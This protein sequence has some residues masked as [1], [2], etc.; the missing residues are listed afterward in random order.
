MRRRIDELRD[1]RKRPGVLGNR[2]EVLGRISLQEPAS[3]R[4][5]PQHHAESV[6]V[7]AS[8]AGVAV[9]DFR[10]HVA[11]LGEH[12][13]R[14][15]VA[16]AVLPAR[17]AEVDQLHIAA[18]AEHH[19]LGTQI[20]VHDPQWLAADVHALVHVHERFGCGGRHGHCI[21]PRQAIGKRKGARAHFAQ[22][23][24]FHELDHH[25]RLAL[26]VGRCLED[27]RHTRV[28]ELRLHARFVEE[29]RKEGSILGMF[30]ADDLDDAGA[31]GAFDA[32]GSSEVDLTHASAS[33]ELEQPVTL[34]SSSY[35]LGARLGVTCCMGKFGHHAPMVPM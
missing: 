9:G 18:I 14:D 13:A 2:S 30:A 32:S 33:D 7:H 16:P 25:E 27:L 31:L 28:L 3:S 4:Q 17:S 11:R 15:R 26:V 20:A 21:G 6:Q 12:H 19:V 29:T 8:I 24:A 5:L 23:S 1:R 22:A 34:E 10:S 35:R